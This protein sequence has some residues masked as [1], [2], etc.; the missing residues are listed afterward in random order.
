MKKINLYKVGT[1]DYYRDTLNNIGAI[2]SVDYD[3]FNSNSAKQM[4]ELLI[5]IKRM[6]QD[7]LAHKKLYR[8]I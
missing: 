3:G 2:I 1:A 5:D 7:T 6:I 4:R 8:T